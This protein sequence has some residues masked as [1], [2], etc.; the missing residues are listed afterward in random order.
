MG[1]REA[2]KPGCVDLEMLSSSP[3]KLKQPLGEKEEEED[4]S[5]SG[6]DSGKA[7]PGRQE[8]TWQDQEAKHQRHKPSRPS[9]SGSSCRSHKGSAN[10]EERRS[11]KACP[12]RDRGRDRAESSRSK[13]PCTGGESGPWKKQGHQGRGD[14]IYP[15]WDLPSW[16]MEK[17]AV[18]RGCDS[19]HTKA[20]VRDRRPHPGSPAR[21]PKRRSSGDSRGEPANCPKRRRQHGPEASSRRVLSPLSRA[22]NN[23][24]ALEV[25]LD[26]LQAPGGAYLRVPQSSTE[27]SVSQRAWLT[28]Q[29]SHAGAALHWALHTVDS[30]LAAQAWMPRYT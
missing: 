27:P 23:V 18:A 13:Q 20:R 24:H 28:W 5:H 3:C 8:N 17:D 15:G 29:L 4:P 19:P 10:P 2:M 26:D 7:S 6:G 1:E 30:I 9:W 14:C 25:I 16:V 22:I 11:E 21:G 12:S